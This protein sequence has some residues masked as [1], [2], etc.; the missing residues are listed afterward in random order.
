QA[1]LRH[2]AQGEADGVGRA[3]RNGVE[4]VNPPRVI[5]VVDSTDHPAVR[6]DSIEGHYVIA[7]RQN[8]GDHSV[9][10]D[11]LALGVIH[12][13]SI[14]SGDVGAR[15][16]DSDCPWAGLR[17]QATTWLPTMGIRT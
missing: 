3:P 16:G 6:G 15:G 11:G 5:R 8:E 1:A 12:P 14:A 13:D 9:R 17:Q 10:P 4:V 7:R 2:A